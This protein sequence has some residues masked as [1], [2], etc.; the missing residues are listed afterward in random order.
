MPTIV[1][2]VTKKYDSA[3][4]HSCKCI[5]DPSKVMKI[6]YPKKD[7]IE[8]IVCQRWEYYIF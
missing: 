5:E 1:I 2:S 8:M 7:I 4:I 3:L 6:I